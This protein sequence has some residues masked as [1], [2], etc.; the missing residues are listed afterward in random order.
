[1]FRFLV[2]SKAMERYANNRF[3]VLSRH[4]PDH[5]STRRA[6]KM[7]FC[8]STNDL[9]L[10]KIREVEAGMIVM[11]SRVSRKGDNIPRYFG[12]SFLSFFL[13]PS[14]VFF[15]IGLS[16]GLAASY[17]GRA[18]LGLY[19]KHSPFRLIQTIW[20]RFLVISLASPLIVHLSL[21]SSLRLTTF[22]GRIPHLCMLNLL[23]DP[24]RNV[25]GSSLKN[26]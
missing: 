13:F 14:P 12:E 3:I 17:E 1:M 5:A 10:F 15:C 19:T 18:V 11:Y 21:G 22:P 24:A 4:H 20:V 16:I 23:Q 8:H 26:R 25:P 2:R 7:A 9:F 6:W